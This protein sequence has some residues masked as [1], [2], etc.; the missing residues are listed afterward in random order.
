MKLLILR[1]SSI[2]DIVLTTPLL[3]CLKTQLKDVVIHY[4]TKKSF[5]SLLENNVYLDKI[6]LLDDSDHKLIAELKQ[7][8]YDLVIDLHHNLRTFRIKKALGVKAYS[9]NKLNLKKALLVT[10]K[11]NQ[12]PKI[13]IVDRYMETVAR[14]GVK[15]DLKGLDYFLNKEDVYDLHQL[16]LSFNAGFVAFAIGGQH[17]TKRLPVHKIIELCQNIKEPIVLLGGGKDDEQTAEKVVNYFSNQEKIVSLVSKLSLNQSAYLVQKAIKVITHDTGMMHIAAA[18]KKEIIVIWG[19][20]VPDFGMY[21]YLTKYKNVEVA[22]LNCRPCSK[23]GFDKCPKGHFMCM[24]N[25]EFN[26]I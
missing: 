17:F 25:Q 9:Y 1:F 8:N 15:N 6:H 2:G 26:T 20:T 5:S 16:P 19:N 14:L 23:I 22:D 24:E 21:P 11:I 3:R 10:L 13:H 18:F 7:E 12:L 4:A